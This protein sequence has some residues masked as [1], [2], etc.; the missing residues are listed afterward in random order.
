MLLLTELKGKA[1]AAKGEW[2][3]LKMS[4]GRKIRKMTQ[5][6][7][8]RQRRMVKLS[9]MREFFLALILL[10]YNQTNKQKIKKTA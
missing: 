9:T 1:D 4:R 2:P 6:K 3:R 8:M 7:R 10:D 5:R